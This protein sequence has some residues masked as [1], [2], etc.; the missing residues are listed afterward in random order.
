MAA[1]L[2][3]P[4]APL[5]CAVRNRAAAA[6]DLA[7]LAR[8]RQPAATA[9]RSGAKSH[10]GGADHCWRLCCA[11]RGGDTP[12]GPTSSWQPA[13]TVEPDPSPARCHR[14]LDPLHPLSSAG[15]GGAGPI[16]ARP[17][18]RGSPLAAMA[19]ELAELAA[20]RAR[21]VDELAGRR[22]Q[23]LVGGALLAQCRGQQSLAGGSAQWPQQL[24]FADAGL[25]RH[26][27]GS[28]V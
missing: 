7:V 24:G 9:A 21:T 10:R 3:E 1:E 12:A 5:R 20:S 16:A 26:R 13:G 15:G 11:R 8:P 19:S 17:T 18:R 2:A 14:G 23:R 22:P 25:H 4:A 27:A 28:S 6:A